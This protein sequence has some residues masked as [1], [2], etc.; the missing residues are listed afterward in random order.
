MEPLSIPYKDA[1]IVIS[2]L[3]AE[4]NPDA[5]EVDFE[6]MKDGVVVTNNYDSDEVSTFLENFFDIAI[7]EALELNK[8]ST[9]EPLNE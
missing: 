2:R 9:K 3:D 8:E 4:S 1:F 5:L 7:L 6:V